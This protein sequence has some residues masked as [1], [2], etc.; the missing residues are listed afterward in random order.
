MFHFFLRARADQFF[1]A[2]SIERDAENDRARV[3]SIARMV[4]RSLESARTER[5]GLVRRLDS[6]VTRAVALSGNAPDEYLTRDDADTRLLDQCEA[7]IQKG[8]RRLDE[9]TGNI[10]HL[11]FIRAALLTRFSD[12]KW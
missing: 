5:A 6:A 3:A 12:L 8:R 7:E 2:R 10:A 11:K 1:N 9:L 4:E